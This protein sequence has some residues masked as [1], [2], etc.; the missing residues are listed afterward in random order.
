[1][2]TKPAKARHLLEAG[3][4]KV[5]RVK[6]FT[7]QLNYATGENKQ[8][9]VVG[10][11]DG[12][13]NAGIAVISNAEVIMKGNVKIR[14]NVKKL[15]DQRRSRRKQRRRNLRHRQPRYLNNN[16]GKGWIPP[17]LKVRKDNIIRVVEE[18]A[19]LVPIS[20][21]RVEQTMFDVAQIASDKD[22]QG[23]DYQQGL[24]KGWENRKYAVL[25]RDEYIC[26]Y[27][28]TDM[29]KNNL[30]AEVDHIIPKSRGGRDNFK[31]L[32]AACQD[33]NQAKGNKTAEEVGYPDLQGADFSVP[34]LLNASKNY[35]F[36]GLEKVATT[37]KCFGYET[38]EWRRELSL[39]KEH[40]NDAIAI[41]VRGEGVM[42]NANPLTFIAGRR[43]RDMFNLKL[44]E[45]GGLRHWDLVKVVFKRGK[46]KGQRFLGTVRGFVSERGIVKV[47]LSFDDNC[48]VSLKQ[49]S[50]VQ[51]S[52]S[53]VF[54]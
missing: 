7:I 17:S 28:G 32:I 47:R 54:C 51:R 21:I 31:N 49:I 48:G 35:L 13:K 30:I 50:L 52:G 8:D 53:V 39:E 38:K 26:G 11:D 46:R 42:D 29:L 34:A 9:V 2:P 24:A 12:V 15:I 45:F 40:Y 36:K 3:K 19:K 16:W 37:E 14:N 10:I 6:P 25:F 33:C 43:N 41:A 5:V 20:L 1:M 27:C 23:K 44:I 22:L 4:A 18:I